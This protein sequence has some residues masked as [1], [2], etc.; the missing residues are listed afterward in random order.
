L[1]KGHGSYPVALLSSGVRVLSSGVCVLSSGVPLFL[2][3]ENGR[4]ERASASKNRTSHGR[5]ELR[6]KRKDQ[7]AAPP[8]KISLKAEAV[9]KN[10]IAT[11]TWDFCRKERHL[12]HKK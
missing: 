4:V 6:S 10:P 2:R 12:R 5:T 9:L 3:V 11:P 7:P 1:F 8:K